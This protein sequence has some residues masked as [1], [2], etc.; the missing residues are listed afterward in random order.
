V[1]VYVCVRVCLRARSRVCVYVCVCVGVYVCLCVC[2]CMLCVCVCVC[3]NR[4]SKHQQNFSKKDL[5]NIFL[6]FQEC[7]MQKSVYFTLSDLYKSGIEL[8]QHQNGRNTAWH[9]CR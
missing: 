8:C 5:L 9:V 6:S 7:C 4:T 2:V 3:V 1:C